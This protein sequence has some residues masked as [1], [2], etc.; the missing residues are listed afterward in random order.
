MKMVT[1]KQA[2]EILNISVITLRR[3]IYTGNLPYTRSN[4]A[5]QGKILLNLDVVQ[6]VLL[7]EALANQKSSSKTT[8]NPKSTEQE[9]EQEAE[10]FDVSALAE[11]QRK[12]TINKSFTRYVTSKASMEDT[13]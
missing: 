7:S 12:A 9:Q 11:V 13:E 2:S 8:A 10:L 5:K 1:L 6:Q 4:S 3:R